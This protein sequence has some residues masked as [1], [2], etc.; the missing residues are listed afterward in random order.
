MA[1]PRH[2]NICFTVN[3]DGDNPLR[4]LDPLDPT[5]VHCKYLVYQREMGE[6]EHFQGYMELTT[7]KTYDALHAMAGLETAH[8]ERRRGTAKQADHYCR[9]PLDGCT[10]DHCEGERLDPTK[11]E[12]PWQFGEM[13]QQGQRADLIEV[14][15]ELVAG[16]SLKRIADEHFPEW[17]RFRSS[18]KEYKRMITRPR[19]FKPWVILLV[20]PAGIGK[21]RLAEMMC[22]IL[23]ETYKVPEKH[24]GFWC[25]DY[26]GED[27]FFLDEMDGHRMTPTFFNGLVDRYEFVLPAHGHAGT[28]FVS[29]YIVICSNY[30]PK[31]WWRKRTPHQ[32]Q[33]TTR[34]I[35]MIIPLFDY[36]RI[37]RE[38]R[39]K[40]PSPP[41]QR[42]VTV[43]NRFPPKLSNTIVIPLNDKGKQELD[44]PEEF[45]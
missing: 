44:D 27:V 1:T 6:H 28:Q 26:Q 33:Q 11:L 20:G 10:C 8:F 32:V 5:W 22:S 24:T 37:H 7:P 16:A 29:H 25:D 31:F 21:T 12:G 2:R 30:L 13:S 23:G 39:A 42:I 35:D 38:R 45:R 9:K 14:Q 40:N 15:R 4:L 34:R 41:K 17:V 18:F 36:A 19:N 3:A 43:L